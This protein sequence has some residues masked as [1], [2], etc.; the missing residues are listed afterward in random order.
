M[1]AGLHLYGAFLLHWHSKHFTTLNR[2]THSHTWQRSLTCSSG[3]IQHFLS[4]FRRTHAV[5]NPLYLLSGL[6]RYSFSVCVLICYLCACWCH[7]GWQT[8]CSPPWHRPSISGHW[9]SL[10]LIHWA[11]WS[12]LLWWH[13]CWCHPCRFFQCEG[14]RP[15]Q[16][17]T[18][19]WRAEN[20]ATL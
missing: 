13:F 19:T 8:Q 7:P 15:S 10:V 11:M 14:C 5:C 18:G 3:S 20:E 2:F 6:S 12:Y 4:K 17:N 9:W 1:M 16:T